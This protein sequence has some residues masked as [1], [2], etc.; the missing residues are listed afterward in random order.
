MLINSPSGFA[1]RLQTPILL[2]QNRQRL[3]QNLF[4]QHL[5]ISADL[6]LSSLP[7][8]RPLFVFE[9]EM[10]ALQAKQRC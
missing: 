4:N 1:C 8:F 2:A 5:L 6:R 7:G 10:R 3:R 9:P